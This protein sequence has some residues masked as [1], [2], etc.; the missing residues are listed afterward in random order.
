MIGQGSPNASRTPLA[1][2]DWAASRPWR[3]ALVGACLL[4][5]MVAPAGAED[6]GVRLRIAWGGGAEKVWHGSIHLG[7]GQFSVL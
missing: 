1:R 4:C 7:R 6:L 2:V 5:L 3:A